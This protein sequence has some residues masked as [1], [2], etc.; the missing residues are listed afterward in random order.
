MSTQTYVNISLVTVDTA[1]NTALV[2]LTFKLFKFQMFQN[3]LNLLNVPHKKSRGVNFGLPG[4]H[5]IRRRLA[6]HLVESKDCLHCEFR[7][8]E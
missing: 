1:V 8:F 5:A 4:G 7:Q 2:I 6:L 3:K